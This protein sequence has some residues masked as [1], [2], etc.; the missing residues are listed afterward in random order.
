MLSALG[1]EVSRGINTDILKEFLT[2]TMS[3][4]LQRPYNLLLAVQD[5][6]VHNELT[7]LYNPKPLFLKIF[8]VAGIMKQ[9]RIELVRCKPQ[10][11]A[12]GFDP[13][14]PTAGFGVGPGTETQRRPGTKNR[15]H[16]KLNT[17]A[18]NVT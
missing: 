5:A 16:I 18:L 12:R 4:R 15:P 14:R 1:V 13:T 3:N 6:N 17:P 9:P 8:G 11:A 2:A 10:C 7:Y